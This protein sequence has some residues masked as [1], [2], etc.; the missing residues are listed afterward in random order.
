MIRIAI[1]QAVYDAIAATMLLGSVNYEAKTD[2]KGK[3]HMSLDPH[4][5]NKLADQRGPRPS[6]PPRR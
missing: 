5:V 2:A 6:P 1:T 4:V 3:R